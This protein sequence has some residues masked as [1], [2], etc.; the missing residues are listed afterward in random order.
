[1]IPL[2]RIGRPEEQAQAI[3]FLLSE[4][5]SYITG[6]VIPVMAAIHDVLYTEVNE[7]GG[8]GPAH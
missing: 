6:Q 8:N 3:I 1:M 5:S 2:G 4:K 7:T